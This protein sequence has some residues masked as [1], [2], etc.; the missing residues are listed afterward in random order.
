MCDK[1]GSHDGEFL[2]LICI[3]SSCANKGLICSICK[4]ES[5]DKHRVYPLR[6]FMEEIEKY[7]VI[8]ETSQVNRNLSSIQ[9]NKSEILSSLQQIVE[10]L[11]ESIKKVEENIIRYYAYVQREVL[12]KVITY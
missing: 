1:G 6:M 9:N 12:I 2:N 5:H 4:A 11:A 3:E 8:T 7:N 10:K